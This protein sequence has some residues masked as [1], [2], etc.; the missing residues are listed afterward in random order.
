MMKRD[1]AIYIVF[2]MIKIST[3]NGSGQ[4][5][6]GHFDFLMP[7]LLNGDVTSNRWRP[8]SANKDD[9]GT[10]QKYFIR[11]LPIKFNHELIYVAF[12]LYRSKRSTPCICFRNFPS[13]LK[14]TVHNRT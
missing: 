1:T 7:I 13:L 11:A 5:V 2:N 3:R 4:N 10:W 6:S 9:A 14:R 12:I 8:D